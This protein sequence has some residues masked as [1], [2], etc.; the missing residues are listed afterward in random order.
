VVIEDKFVPNH[1]IVSHK[2]MS[3]ATSPGTKLHTDPVYR[4][5]IWSFVPFT[6]SAPAC[7]VAQGAL[8]AFIDE[9]KVRDDSFAHSPLSKKPGMH[10]RVAEASAMIDCGDLLYKLGRHE[11]ARAAFAAAAELAGNKREQELLRR[12]ATDAANAAAS[13]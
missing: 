1:R 8:D 11:E 6:I 3:D 13:S 4:T 5:P 7:G 9:M 2:E 10:A 12:R